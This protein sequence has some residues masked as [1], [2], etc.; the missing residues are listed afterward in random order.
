[1]LE[2][3][4]VR[5]REHEADTR[6]ADAA[7]NPLRRQVDPHAQCRQHVGGTGFR[8][9][10]FVAVLRDRD[11]SCRDDAECAELTRCVA[12]AENP[13]DQYDCRA[14][15]VE[16]LSKSIQERD[17]GGP[18][19]QC[20]FLSAC[21]SECDAHSQLACT[22]NY[23]WPMSNAVVPLHLR[24][25]EGLE[26]NPVAGLSVRACR[27][28]NPLECQPADSTE[29]I[30]ND[31]GV[32]DLEVQP[33][34]GGFQGYLELSGAGIYPSLL[35]FG[36]PI[37]KEVVTNVAV[38]SKTNVS[39]LS[40]S[41][42]VELDKQRGLLQLRAFGCYG[43]STRDVSFEVDGTDETTATWYTTAQDLL[44]S[45]EATSTA[46]RGAGGIINVLPGRRRVT[47]THEGE[48]IASLSAP[49]RPEHMT[50][51]VLLPA[52]SL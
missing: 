25:V 20:V 8:R 19:Q 22:G 14:Q 46:D 27:T 24:F 45:F 3:R 33:S 4:V 40:F 5:G 9:Q 17:I 7:R 6:L 44:P 37:A 35:R 21:A 43:I 16:W 31:D 47:A 18:Y 30:T 39:L 32:V 49:V 42:G 34:L 12:K 23:D 2:S 51:V 48:L 41:A 50:I 36:W 38:V 26:S 29:H 1:M 13:A 28:E 10:R 15:H 11:A 52:D